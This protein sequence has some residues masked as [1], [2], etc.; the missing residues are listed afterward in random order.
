M[1]GKKESRKIEIGS[2]VVLKRRHK[3]PNASAMLR[4]WREEYGGRAFRIEGMET[5]NHVTLFDLKEGKTV[6][7]GSTGDPS[8]HV[9]FVEP[10]RLAVSG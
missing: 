5:P 9:G 10:R 2:V 6:H 7:F 1:A 3:D 8:L 4:K